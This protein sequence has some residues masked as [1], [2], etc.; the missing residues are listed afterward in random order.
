ML[1]SVSPC[2]R[3]GTIESSVDVESNKVDQ[4]PDQSVLVVHAPLETGH[5]E[6]TNPRFIASV[7]AK[8]R[9]FDKALISELMRML[10]IVFLYDGIPTAAKIPIM[11]NVIIISINVNPLLLKYIFKLSV[12]FN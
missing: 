10:V 2:V 7:L 1:V 12:S 6:I 9:L 11:A 3:L 8:F 5:T 4:P